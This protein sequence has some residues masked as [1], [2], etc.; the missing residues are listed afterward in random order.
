MR[1][2]AGEIEEK[3]GVLYQGS[4]VA[5]LHFNPLDGTVLPLGIHPRACQPPLQ[6]QAVKTRLGAVIH[7]LKILPVAEFMEPEASWSFPVALG[8]A[9]VAHLKV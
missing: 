3:A 6:V 2:P 8:N 7:E 1:G 9:I 5:V 4:V